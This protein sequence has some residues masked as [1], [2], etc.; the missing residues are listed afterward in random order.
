[1]SAPTGQQASTALL[2]IR[3]AS[4]PPPRLANTGITT[5]KVEVQLNLAEKRAY[6]LGQNYPN[7][8]N[9]GTAIQFTLPK[10]GK[11]NLS[12]FDVS[13]RAVKVLVNGSKDAGTHTINFNV[14]SLTKGVYYYR[15]QA[16]DFTDVK[17]LTI[18]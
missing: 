3:S 13:G 14:G 18:Q 2:E 17:K 11:V 15:M 12:L 16:G 4:P 5:T 9:S 6:S 7:P 8:A 10:A 1:V